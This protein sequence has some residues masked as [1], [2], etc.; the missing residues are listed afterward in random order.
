[1]LAVKKYVV[2]IFLAA[3]FV[4]AVFFYLFLYN[5]PCA[6]M[7][8]SAHYH[9]GAV[10]ILQQGAFVDV[11]GQPLFHRLPGYSFFLAGL[12]FLTNVNVC[13]ALMVQLIFA[14]AL[15]VLIYRIA[16]Q[17]TN[18]EPLA[19]VTGVLGVIAPGYMIF[20]GLVMSEILFSL[21]FLCF[22]SLFLHSMSKPT[23]V[24][25][26]AGAGVFLGLTSLVRP[27]GHLLVP[28]ILLFILLFFKG[29]LLLRVKQCGFFA[30]SWL[31]I[32]G[33][34][35][36]RNFLLTGYLFFHTLPGQH[37]INHVAARIVADG[38]KIA[39]G[40]AKK[41]VYTELHD[42][43][44]RLIKELARKPMDIET[45]KLFERITIDIVKNYPLSFLKLAVTNCCKTMCALYSS[46]LLVIDANGI[47][48]S[49]DRAGPVKT[50]KRY[51]YPQVHNRGILFVIYFEILLLL[52]SI[53]G[54]CLAVTRY[55]RIFF[56]P[57]TVLVV[58]L[59]G[60]FVAI[61]FGC[62]YARLRLPIEVFYL[63]AASYAINE[64]LT[65]FRGYRSWH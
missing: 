4:Y 36:V 56:Q 61:S 11:G 17:L 28:A 60:F 58:G 9:E 40:D 18:S 34:W 63:L 5:N 33:P 46:E 64:V 26:V 24:L 14:A 45:C 35:L 8:D 48:P 7:Y 3:F 42:E 55:W 22:V 12:Y 52:L 6:L 57:G 30:G 44:A 49:Y 41:R 53:L 19:R 51:L 2:G 23:Q 27:V 47:L 65:W 1:M 32:V 31:F 62:G 16:N 29:A 10:G 25:P 21:L 39:Y 13:A 38:D 20:A 50:I 37:F 43:E 15:P 59:V 54:T